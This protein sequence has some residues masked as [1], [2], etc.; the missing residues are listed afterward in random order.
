MKKLNSYTQ[1][2]MLKWE[3]VF[4]LVLVFSGA[5]K[6]GKGDYKVGQQ[7]ITKAVSQI[8]GNIKEYLI[9]HNNVMDFH[10]HLKD[11]GIVLINQ[12]HTKTTGVFAHNDEVTA[13]LTEEC[14]KNSYSVSDVIFVTKSGGLYTDW[15]TQKQRLIKRVSRANIDSQLSE[16]RETGGG[17]TGGMSE[18]L[19]SIS[20]ILKHEIQRVH[21]CSSHHIDSF[22]SHHHGCSWTIFY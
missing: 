6:I 10:D 3:N 22:T 13:T 9:H 19:I 1:Q 8:V 20:K 4:R 2:N 14:V 5:K 21:L 18:K 12:D 11:G 17:G 15:G 16:C 7:K